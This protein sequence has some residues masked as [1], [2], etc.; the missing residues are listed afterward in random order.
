MLPRVGNIAVRREL[1]VHAVR[2]AAGPASL[3]ADRS[4]ASCEWTKRRLSVVDKRLSKCRA[5]WRVRLVES[6][7]RRGRIE[8]HL[9][10]GPRRAVPFVRTAE[11]DDE[12]HRVVE[13]RRPLNRALD[14]N[15]I[16]ELELEH[17]APVH[18]LAGK[19][20]AAAVRV[21]SHQ[22]GAQSLPPQRRNRS[23]SGATAATAHRT[24]VLS[25]EGS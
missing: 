2:Q 12:E 19:R 24:R 20:E 15:I 25:L 21:R 16:L 23:F 3:A 6:E 8:P 18:A 10:F 17:H 11:P 13:R 5:N 1:R 14:P 4:D 7:I 22:P 9:H